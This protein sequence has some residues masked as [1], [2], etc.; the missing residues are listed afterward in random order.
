ML[1]Y[2]RF[3]YIIIMARDNDIIVK[4][5]NIRFVTKLKRHSN[6]TM[7]YHITRIQTSCYGRYRLTTFI[8]YTRYLN[9]FRRWLK[10]TTRFK[11]IKIIVAILHIFDNLLGTYIYIEDIIVVICQKYTLQAARNMLYLLSLRIILLIVSH[12]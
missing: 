4:K 3:R 7:K 1:G 5:K 11:N 12:I 9:I 10:C 6:R 2:V 8:I